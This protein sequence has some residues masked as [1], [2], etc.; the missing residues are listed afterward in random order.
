[1]YSGSANIFSFLCQ[2][3]D[4][5][6]QVPGSSKTTRFL[7]ELGKNYEDWQVKQAHDA[8]K[9]F[10]YFQKQ[11]SGGENAWRSGVTDKQ[12]ASCLAGDRGTAY[13]GIA[14]AA[15]FPEYG[16]NLC[17]LAAA[18]SPFPAK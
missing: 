4:D 1:M 5:P 2:T 6:E 18:F 9:L 12:P 7:A 13:Q 8:V 14:L 16:K 3:N 10:Q 11:G 17:L 15:P